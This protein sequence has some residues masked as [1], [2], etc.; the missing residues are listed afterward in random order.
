MAAKLARLQTIVALREQERPRLASARRMQQWVVEAAARL[1]GADLPP[2][3][4]TRETIAARFDAW[5]QDLAVQGQAEEVPAVEQRAIAHFVAVTARLRP[6]LLECY[7]VAGLPRTN[8]DMEGFI[9]RAPKKGGITEED[10]VN[11]IMEHR[12]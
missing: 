9:R 2:E 6:H 4:Q 10:V 12:Y 8:N 3:Q 1:A 7:A 11:E 5:W